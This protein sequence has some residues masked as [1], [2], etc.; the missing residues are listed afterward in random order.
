M[1]PRESG[2]HSI[3]TLRRL[4]L[5]ILSAPTLAPWQNP[6]SPP[7]SPHPS[8][9]AKTTGI[10]ESCKL[11]V[12]SERGQYHGEKLVGIILRGIDKPLAV[13]SIC[14][15]YRSGK[16]YFMS[17]LLGRPGV[18]STC[19]SQRACTHGTWTATLIH[20][21]RQGFHHCA[22]CRRRPEPLK[23]WP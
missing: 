14:C 19:R 18:R 2:K 9:H 4:S 8:S 20:V 15:L 1:K 6:S 10:R 11:Q 13:L 5:R 16:S 21:V 3:T 7:P 22:E 23:L 17:R 12:S